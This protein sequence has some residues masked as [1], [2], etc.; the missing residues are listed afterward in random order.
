[1]SD[2]GHDDVEAWPRS[3]LASRFDATVFSHEHGMRKPHPEMYLRA[4]TAIGADAWDAVFVGDGG[5]DE[6]RG[7]RAVGL[8]AVLVTRLCDQW[9]PGR[10]LSRAE[11]ADEVHDDVAAFVDSRLGATP[12]PR[13]DR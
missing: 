7:A 8:H 10:A 6:L 3:P 11:H 2:A 12:V 13:Q 4:L 9:W 1:V 5:S